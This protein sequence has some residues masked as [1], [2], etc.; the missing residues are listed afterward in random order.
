MALPMSCTSPCTVPM[1]MRPLA[2]A[3]CAFEGGVGD[4]GGP[5]HGVGA[6]HQLGEE[7]LAAL[8]ELADLLDALDEAVLP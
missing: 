1:T 7:E 4:L 5:G 3:A 6:H 8:E 2:S